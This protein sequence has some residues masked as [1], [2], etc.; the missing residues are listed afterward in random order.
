MSVK[1]QN[2][3]FIGFRASPKVLSFIQDLETLHP[4]MDRAELLKLA[5]EHY[6][7]ARFQ[8][9]QVESLPDSE[10]ILEALEQAKAGK[11]NIVKHTSIQNYLEGLDS[12]E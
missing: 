8:E 12:D 9:F 1:T 11:G 2:K 6:H 3:A 10:G 5:L 7:N 4:L